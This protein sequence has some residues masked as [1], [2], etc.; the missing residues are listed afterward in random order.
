[1]FSRHIPPPI[2]T[3]FKGSCATTIGMFVSP[4][5]RTSRPCRSAPPPVRT[6]PWLHDVG[7]ELRR[8]LVERRLDRVDDRR[9]RLLDR[10]ADVLGRGDDRLRQTRDEVPTADLGVQLLLELAGG[11]DRDLDLLGG[12]L[13]EREAVLLLRRRR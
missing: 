4:A 6:I 1:M 3:Q 2:A 7:D 9:D 11:A 5:S 8:R 12:A 13:A 10:L